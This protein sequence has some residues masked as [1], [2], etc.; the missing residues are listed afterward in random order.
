MSGLTKKR[1]TEEAIEIRI[2]G[3]VKKRE[4][5]LRAINRLGFEP[6]MDETNA[7]PWRSVLTE[8]T[9]GQ[10]LK[11]ARTKEGLTQRT[12]SDLAGIPQRHLSEMENDKRP[13]GKKTAKVLAETLKID[14]RVFL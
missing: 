9:P 13:I 2:R 10:A 6:V 1:L 3:P 14:H 12:L 5:V 7:L 8:P 11:G 4:A